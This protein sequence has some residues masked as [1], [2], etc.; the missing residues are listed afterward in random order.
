MNRSTRMRRRA[1]RLF[2]TLVTTS[3]L[4]SR[5]DRAV[6]RRSP[7]GPSLIGLPIA[8][9]HPVHV[10]VAP[11]GGGNIGDQAMVE[12]FLENTDGR[13]CIVV[14]DADDLK[15]P[16][17]HENRVEIC[18]LPSLLHGFGRQH[19]RDLAALKRLLWSA[20]SLSVVGADA[21]DGAY[22]V[23]GSVH[24]ADIATL[25]AGIGV[26][27]RVLGF[28]WNGHARPAARR[29]L[30]RAGRAGVRL[31]LRDP[32]SAQRARDDGLT[33]VE[34]T[35]DVVFSARTVSSGAVDEFLGGR[36]GGRAGGAPGGA[37]GGE[38][39]TPWAVVNASGFVGRSID[40]IGAYEEIVRWLLDHGMTVV[41]LPHVLRSSSS[42]IVACRLVHD[43]VDDPRVILVDRMLSPA[44][45]RGL[46]AGAQLVL[47]GRMHLAI[48]AL[49]S[50]V[51]AIAL[52]T[53]GK[54][55]GLM[56]MVG[57]ESLSVE[58]GEDLAER[59]IPILAELL[60]HRERWSSA[61]AQ[62]LPTVRTM[63]DLNFRALPEGT[64]RHSIRQETT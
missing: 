50:T 61:V 46:C 20:R 32:F 15:L 11:P 38:D 3:G 53:Q 24:R 4:S 2:K 43:R 30:E 16:A 10:L 57:T 40:Q 28:S 33:G 23:R 26:D 44:E 58:P 51:P 41:L 48:Q 6:F 45:V 18:A 1:Y 8:D 39:A 60:A 21:M 37:L 29:A 9:Q 56:R 52:S 42:D 31:L 7:T 49:W 35:A 13:V 5:I 62:H 22:D 17:E 12:A 59:A 64:A 63:A 34:E 54:V 14:R 55:D 27:S 25:A 47:T 19:W 36:A